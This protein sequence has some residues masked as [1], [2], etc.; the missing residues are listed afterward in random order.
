MTYDGRE[1]TDTANEARFTRAQRARG[2]WG[3]RR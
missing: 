1:D 3:A 2:V